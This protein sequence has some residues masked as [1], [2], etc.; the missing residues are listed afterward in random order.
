V[1]K[2]LK[3]DFNENMM[4]VKEEIKA[5]YEIQMGHLLGL[6]KKDGLMANLMSG[7]DE[8]EEEQITTPSVS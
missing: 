5:S 2:S 3:Q 7:D 1:V 6:L 8:K 4:F